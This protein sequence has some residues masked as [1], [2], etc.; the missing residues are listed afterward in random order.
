MSVEITFMGEPTFTHVW[1]RNPDDPAMV[2]K[3]SRAD[4]DQFIDAVGLDAFTYR[5]DGWIAPDPELLETFQV[6]KGTG[7]A[8][9]TRTEEISDDYWAVYR[10]GYRGD[11]AI[12][13]VLG[14]GPTSA[15]RYKA[16][17]I[18]HEATNPDA[19]PGGY[20]DTLEA[21]AESFVTKP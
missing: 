11:E 1:V 18:N 21:A 14:D 3:F 17:S 6:T 20:F 5:G 4:W 9:R 10:A 2:A 15:T 8:T 7:M 19:A 16:I 12:G 13:H